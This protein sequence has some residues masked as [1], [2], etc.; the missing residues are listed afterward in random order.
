M[1]GVFGHRQAADGTR[2]VVVGGSGIFI[3]PFQTLTARHV[4]LD[5]FRTDAYRYDDLRKR[6]RGYFELPHS[7]ALFQVCEPFGPSPRSAIW[8]VNRTWDPVITD[9]C[10]MEVSADGGESTELQFHMPPRFFEWSLLPPPVGSRVVMLGFPKTEI[11]ISGDLMNT[12]YVYAKQEGQ[13]TDAYEIKRDSGKYTF[14]C[15]RIDQPV[16]HGFSG[17][18]VFWQNR[19][20]GIVSGG[21]VD[22]STYAASLWPMCLMDYAYP[23]QGEIGRKRDFSDLFETGVLQS[24]DWPGVKDCISRQ[25]D[26]DGKAFASITSGAVV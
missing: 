23:D 17:G 13:V 19:L 25:C 10:Y 15:F 1:F 2:T 5:L 9:I 3:A 12:D 8:Q 22:D 4:C 21:S 26:G 6:T 7:S 24:V 14:P 11:K 20:C 18:P 16:D